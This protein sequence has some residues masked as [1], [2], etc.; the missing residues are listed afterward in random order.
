MKKGN[1]KAAGHNRILTYTGFPRYAD[2]AFRS[3]CDC[4]DGL[5]VNDDHFLIEIVDPATGKNVPD[6]MSGEVVFTALTKRALPAHTIQHPRYR[7]RHAREV[8]VRAYAYT[9]V[10]DNPDAAT[11][12]SSY[13]A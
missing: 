8:R 4:S 2:R 3:G 13:A 1:R 9:Y 7:Q 12:C 5:H 11:T 10:K 6:G